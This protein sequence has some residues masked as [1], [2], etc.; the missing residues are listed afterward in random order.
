MIL[1]GER[2]AGVLEVER[3]DGSQRIVITHP[4]L[5][6]DPNGRGSIVLS[7]RHAR[8]LANLLI[9]H[10]EE[11]EVQ[12]SREVGDAVIRSSSIK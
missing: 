10:A 3:L 6:P 2:V 9:L 5:K 8:H 4:D 12:V 7:L 1:S 11:A